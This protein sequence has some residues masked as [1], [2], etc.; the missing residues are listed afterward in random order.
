[1]P[2][3]WWLFHAFTPLGACLNDPLQ[4]GR[5]LIRF[6]HGHGFQ[7]RQAAHLLRVHQSGPVVFPEIPRL[8]LELLFVG[9]AP[10]RVLDRLHRLVREGPGIIQGFYGEL[11]RDALWF[12][13]RVIHKWGSQFLVS[14]SHS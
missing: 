7:I 11:S 13:S 10:L 9:K 4:I 1:M 2:C 3:G 8:L 5:G 6:R 14:L 12:R